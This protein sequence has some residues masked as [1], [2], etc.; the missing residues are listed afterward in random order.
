MTETRVFLVGIVVFYIEIVASCG[1]KGKHWDRLIVNFLTPKVLPRTEDSA[2][3][4]GWRNDASCD[5]DNPFYG[6]RYVLGNDLSTRLLFDNDGKL[7]GIQ[8]T[9]TESDDLILSPTR[10]RPAAFV[11]DDHG[12][13]L[14]TAYLTKKPQDICKKR[15]HR[16]DDDGKK[17]KHYKED[18]LVIQMSDVRLCKPQFMEIPL[19]AK[20]LANTKWVEGKCFNKMGVHYWYD[21]SPEMHCDQSFPVFLLYDQASQR[22][23]SFGWAALADV[24]SSSWEHPPIPYLRLFFKDVPKCLLSRKV[25]STQHVYLTDP[26]KLTCSE[27]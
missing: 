20:K 23:K 19:D 9:I 16:R 17:G 26:G 1:G 24:K 6:N 25:I 2:L 8:G 18:A 13:Y 21:I 15:K 22:L 11:K 12:H 14:L 27:P 4:L 5:S 3:K 7:A 10:P